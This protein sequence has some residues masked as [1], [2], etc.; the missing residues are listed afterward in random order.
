MTGG[1]EEEDSSLANEVVENYLS[2]VVHDLRTPLAVI[3]TCT[4]FLTSYSSDSLTGEQKAFLDRIDRN[5]EKALRMVA[6]LL[7]V[8]TGK[9]NFHLEKREVLGGDFVE[10]VVSNVSL[11]GKEKNIHIICEASFS[12]KVLIDTDRVEQAIEN[13]IG[14]AIKFS[15]KGKSI[16][17]RTSEG[18]VNEGRYFRIEVVDQG[19]GIPKEK[20]ASIFNKFTQLESG[21]AKKL[22]V[23]LGLT[24]VEQFIK[25]HGGFITVD[26]EE[27]KGSAFQIN[28]PLVAERSNPVVGTTILLVDDDADIREYLAAELESEGFRVVVAKD[29]EDAILKMEVSS[30]DLVISDVQM[31]G[32]DGFEL[33]AAVKKKWSTPM[34]LASGYYPS[35][36]EDVAKSLFKA[37]YFLPKPY[38]VAELLKVVK[39]LLGV[40]PLEEVSA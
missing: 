33:L 24:I 17:V 15:P 18:L 39:E 40:S 4:E 12:P 6:S 32:V 23:G 5:A 36:N 34:I 25:A 7:E 22:G 11:L 28:I 16:I 8:A 14:N 3:T 29:G 31:P 37:D 2:M 21:Y 13:L 10:K 9:G 35:L 38:K 27:G 30:I 19:Q 20:L 26:S 1:E